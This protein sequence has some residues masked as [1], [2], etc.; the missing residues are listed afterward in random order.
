[1]GTGVLKAVEHINTIIAP[2][3]IGTDPA[4]QKIVDDLMIELDG[5]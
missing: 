1:M 4:D 3:P 5:T 2:A